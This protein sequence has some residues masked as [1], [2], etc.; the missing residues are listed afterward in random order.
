M[1]GPLEVQSPPG[2]EVVL[3]GTE[4]KPDAT[5]KPTAEELLKKVEEVGEALRALIVLTKRLP[6][7]PQALDPHQEPGRALSLAQ[8][9]LQTGFMWLRKAIKAPKEF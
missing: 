8:M 9:Y 2:T 5:P 1:S 3:Q 4:V 6:R 7:E